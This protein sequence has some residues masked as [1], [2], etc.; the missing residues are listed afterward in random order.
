MTTVSPNSAFFQLLQADNVTIVELID[1][2]LPNGVVRHWTTCNQPVTYTLSGSATRYT[3]FSGQTPMGVQEDNQ[4]G[5]SVIDFVLQNSD[6]V[7][8]SY[9]DNSDFACAKLKIGRVFPST[10]DLGRME[11]Y[12]GQI[13]DFGYTRAQI[14]GQA[15]NFW[16]SLSIEWPYYRYMDTCGWRF[17]SDG[18]GFNTTSVTYAVNTLNVGSSTTLDLL[19]PTG[20]F[21]AYSDGRFDFGRLTVTAG[22]NSGAIRTIRAHT[23]DLLSLAKDLTNADF[24][25]ITFSIY[26]G[27]RKRLIEDC[28]SLYNNDRNFLG[29]KWIPIQEDAF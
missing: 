12:N 14:K 20:T 22:T 10:P 8:S 27:C 17:G 29:W 26:P 13:G 15:R 24:T 5:V 25:G 28:K 9:L 4:L 18:C 3:P 19:F 6:D 7:I 23:G 2:E 21:S 16:K 11:V 1:F